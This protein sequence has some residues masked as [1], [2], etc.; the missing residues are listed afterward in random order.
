MSLRYDYLANKIEIIFQHTGPTELKK[1]HV[2]QGHEGRRV[3]IILK[4]SQWAIE[5]I[6]MY[7]VAQF[8]QLYQ[9]L[10]VVNKVNYDYQPE[11]DRHLLVPKLIADQILS[12]SESPSNNQ[13]IN[14]QQSNF[15]KGK[16]NLEI[17]TITWN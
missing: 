3:F 10:K 9:I 15:I 6:S 12:K 14:K 7:K 16:V 13:D 1:A 8:M 11:Q 4:D 5:F 17:F 2:M